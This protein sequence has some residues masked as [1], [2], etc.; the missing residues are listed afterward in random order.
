M[1]SLEGKSALVT[2]ATSGI[3]R[4]AAIALA[5]AGAKVVVSGRRQ[6]LGDSLAAE[7]AGRGGTARFIQ[8]DVTDEDHVKVLVNG[9]VDEFG[10]LDIAVNNAGVEGDLGPI[11]EQSAA[12][13]DFI[14]DAN[15]KGVFFSLKHELAKM[16][17][18]GTK[19]SIINTSS[20]AGQIGF[21]G[22]SIYVASKHAVN[23]LTR[24]A[25]L[26]FAEMGIRVNA[27]APGA[28]QTAMIDRFAGGDEGKEMLKSMH[29]MGRLGEADEIANA[30]V[31]LAG[32]GAS[33]VTGQ[34]LPIDG[35]LTTR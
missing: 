35:G 24:T 28:I 2:G 14:M 34:V 26:E 30:I 27:V 15:V 12:N 3:G 25:A 5:D 11:V 17:A 18:M 10:A 4:A 16:A 29:P 9:T 7:I 13:Y 1:K 23:G 32:D 22:A 31:F 19:G 6:E 20:V 8:G 33:F 21:P